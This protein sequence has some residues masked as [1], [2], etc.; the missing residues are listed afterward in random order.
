[1]PAYSTF[2]VYAT[3]PTIELAERLAAIAPIDDAVV[4]FTSGGS[5][6]VD[7]AGK[8]ARRY[9]DVVGKPE[10]RIIV[11][12]EFSYHGMAAFGTSLAGL[13][14]NRQGYGGPI[15]EAVEYVSATDPSALEALFEDHG[16]QV[17]AFIG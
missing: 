14:A 11:S 1:L 2:G 16:D 4:F 15:V 3:K 6:S 8:L 7:T 12:R 17:A 5:E 9:W 13:P 10:R